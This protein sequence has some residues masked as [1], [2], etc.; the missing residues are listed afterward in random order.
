MSG[1]RKAV[2]KLLLLILFSLPQ[3]GFTTGQNQQLLKQ[4]CELPKT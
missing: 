1:C 3:Q 4:V 2:E